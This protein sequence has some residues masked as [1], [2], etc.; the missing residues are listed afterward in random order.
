MEAIFSRRS[1]PKCSD[2]R[3]T[4]EVIN[5]LLEAAV[6]AP[7]HFLTEPW[8]FIVL[9]GRALDEL[10]DAMAERVRKELADSPDLEKKM[11]FERGRPRRAP[12]IVAMVYVPAKSPK[13]VDVED[14]Y[15]MGAAMQNMLL[16]AHAEGMAAYVRTGPAAGDPPVHRYLGLE[17]NEEIAGFVYLGYPSEEM[18]SGGSRRTPASDHT[19]WVG[20]D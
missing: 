17:E 15:A 7:N 9:T 14:R 18:P 3:P 6:R 11:A 1:V 5:R 8:R 13:A 20:W 19:T 2:R 10:G 16:A 4:Q 12:V